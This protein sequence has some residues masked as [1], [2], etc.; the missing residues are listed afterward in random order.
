MYSEASGEIFCY[1]K[2]LQEL[3]RYLL[4]ISHKNLPVHGQE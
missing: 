1:D 4:V 2:I 3:V